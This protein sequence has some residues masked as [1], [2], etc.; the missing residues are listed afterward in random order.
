MLRKIFLVFCITVLLVT[1]SHAF[2]GNC[3]EM[4][5]KAMRQEGLNKNVVLN[6]CNRLS[7]LTDAEKPKITAEKIE[8][9]IA[10]KMVGSWIFQASEWRE[11]DILNSRYSD[12]KARI[13]INV[14]T[15]RNKSGTLRLRYLWTD[16]KWKLVKIFNIDFD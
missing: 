4:F 1:C 13:E 2:A 12:K 9:D 3:P 6:I 11:I 5:V 15:I 8:N 7:Q 16:N 10:G 14:D